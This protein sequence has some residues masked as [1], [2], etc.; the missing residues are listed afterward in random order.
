MKKSI[1][2]TDRLFSDLICK[3][4]ILQDEY[5]KLNKEKEMEKVKY[6]ELMNQLNHEKNILQQKLNEKPKIVYIYSSDSESSS[7]SES[8]SETS[9]DSDSD[10]DFF[11][12][13]PQTRPPVVQPAEEECFLIRAAKKI[14]DAIVKL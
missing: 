11:P 1:Q 10:S 12:R 8:E 4:N 5:N 3:K 2:K 14:G 13:R 7:S 6:E 9:S